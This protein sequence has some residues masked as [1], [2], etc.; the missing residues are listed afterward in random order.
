MKEKNTGIRIVLLMAVFLAAWVFLLPA[1]LAETPDSGRIANTGSGPVVNPH[2]SHLF[3]ETALSGSAAG[4]AFTAA[5]N[6]QEAENEEEAS[7]IV[8]RAMKRR[9]AS[10]KF[11]IRQKQLPDSRQT[12][13]LWSRIWQGALAHTGDPE[14]GDYLEWQW[15]T[16]HCHDAE[17]KKDKAGYQLIFSVDLTYY[18]TADEEKLVTAKIK[19][20]LNEIIREDMNDYEKTLQVYTW[21]CDHVA[22]DYDR[23]YEVLSG[24]MTPENMHIFSAYG[25]VIENRCVCQGYAALLYRMLLELGIDNRLVTS[26]PHAFNMVLMNGSY[27]YVDVTWDAHYAIMNGKRYDQKF[28][29]YKRGHYRFFLLGRVNFEDPYPDHWP[30]RDWPGYRIPDSDYV[31]KK[32][33]PVTGD[34]A[35]PVRYILMLAASLTLF[36]IC[37]TI[38]RKDNS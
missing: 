23:Y 38:R 1:A 3:P 9:K 29:N 15:W 17:W 8:R 20:I 7:A 37:G 13:R 30:E 19:E 5:G 24:R 31:Y 11:S 26:I 36:A 16:Y 4:D 35:D 25:A 10:V 22:Y 21:I 33:V 12:I 32:D 34:S 2:Y 28:G 6:I 18:T 27:Y 14:E